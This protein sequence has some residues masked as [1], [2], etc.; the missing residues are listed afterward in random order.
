MELLRIVV[1]LR[2][3]S[4]LTSNASLVTKVY[5]P[6]EIFPISAVLVSLVDFVIGATVLVGLMIYYQVAPTTAL[7]ALPWVLAVHVMFTLAI[8]MLLAMANLFY[9]DVKYLFE[10]VLT[11]WMFV[12]AVLYPVTQVGGMMGRDHGD[13]PGDADPRSV[14]RRDHPRP[15]ARSVG[16]PDHDARVGGLPG[17]LVGHLPSRGIRVRRERV[18]PRLHAAEPT[19]A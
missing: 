4:S 14:S 13:Q 17:D 10:L 12:S 11:V 9:R 7:L 16:V 6:R 3:V 15:P 2:G 1:P 8:A 5:F 19:G 18:G